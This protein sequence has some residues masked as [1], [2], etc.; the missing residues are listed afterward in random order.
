MKWIW[1]RCRRRQDVSF[2]AAGILGERE[3]M[4]LEEHLAACQ[5]CRSYYAEIKTLT[6][7]WASWEK[8]LSS[9]EATAA[10]QRRWARAV[11]DAGVPSPAHQS[12]L[13]NAWRIAWRE[14]LW[15]NRYAWTG[16]AA[17]WVAMLA[18]NAQFA[19]QRTSGTSA[20]ASSPQEMIQAWQEQNRVLAELIEP[21]SVARAQTPELPRPR[22]QKKQASTII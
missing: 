10:M 16:M 3:K 6:A 18:I 21:A 19:G 15:P 5:E 22:S 1:N 11:Q 12:P 20:R 9:I 2:L 13:K 8:S 7:S 4:A 14:L 17:L